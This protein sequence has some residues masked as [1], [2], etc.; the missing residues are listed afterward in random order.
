[1]CGTYERDLWWWG[2]NTIGPVAK[3]RP[4]TTIS[5]TDGIGSI[6]VMYLKTLYSNVIELK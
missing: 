6:L 4:P 2:P 1:M 5:S 3:K